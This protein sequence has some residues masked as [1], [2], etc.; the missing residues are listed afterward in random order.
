MIDMTS[1]L[2]Y[3]TISVFVDLDD[4]RKSEDAEGNQR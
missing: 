2:V 3:S 4:F 1:K